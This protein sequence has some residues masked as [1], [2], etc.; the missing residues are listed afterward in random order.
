MQEVRRLVRGFLAPV[1]EKRPPVVE[2]RQ[3]V[4]EKRPPATAVD[5]GA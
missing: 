4:V 3:P 5:H 1:V 2:M